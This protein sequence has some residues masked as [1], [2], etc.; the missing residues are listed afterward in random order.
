MLFFTRIPFSSPSLVQRDVS[1]CPPGQWRTIAYGWQHPQDVSVAS[2]VGE[3]QQ[4]ARIPEPLCNRAPRMPSHQSPSCPAVKM[5]VAQDSLDGSGK[6]SC[7]RSTFQPM[8]EWRGPCTGVCSHKSPQLC[9]FQVSQD[10]APD[11]V[12]VQ[13]LPSL[14]TFKWFVSF[15]DAELI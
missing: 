14:T 9:R 8:Q 1:L 5:D 7:V 6:L 10:L 2:K 11:T 4:G 3:Q 12:F 15:E 13:F